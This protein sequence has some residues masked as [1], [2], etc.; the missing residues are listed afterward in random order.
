MKL[1]KF[2]ELKITYEHSNMHYVH[3]A[4]RMLYAVV[5][6]QFKYFFSTSLLLSSKKYLW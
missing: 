1:I 2:N 4:I 6:T 5:I 3:R